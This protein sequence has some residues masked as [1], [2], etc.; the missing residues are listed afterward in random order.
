VTKLATPPPGLVVV[1]VGGSLYDHPRLSQG[2]R[3]YL[4]RLDAPQVLVVAGGGV[5]ADAVRDLTAWQSLDDEAAHWLA[6]TATH[7]AMD[8][9]RELIGA[10][11][12]TASIDWWTYRPD[13]RV[14]PLACTVFLEQYENLFGPVPH[15]WDLT[16][17]SIAAYAAAVGRA[18]LIL[19]KSVDV[20]P[21]TPWEEAAARG[22]V[23]AHFPQ[24]VAAHGLDV[25]VVNFRRRLDTLL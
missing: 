8:F 4:D 22:W 6:M 18:K 9:V 12:Y 7:I 15:T 5:A 13:I 10:N 16:T 20:P 21:G 17:D 23:D 2:L 3:T 24:V 1:K 19:L 14:L 11:R 25:E